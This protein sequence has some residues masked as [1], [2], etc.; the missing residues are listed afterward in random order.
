MLIP[1]LRAR[2]Y[3]AGGVVPPARSSTPHAHT[4]CARAPRIA[5][6][7]AR[8]AAAQPPPAYPRLRMQ[9]MHISDAWRPPE[10][11]ASARTHVF[12]PARARATFQVGKVRRRG[13]R[14]RAA[15]GLPWDLPALEGVCVDPP[16]CRRAR[17]RA[18]ART[19][20][21]AR[22]CAR[23]P[24]C[25]CPTSPTPR[26]PKRPHKARAHAHTARARRT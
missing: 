23:G 13:D 26:T 14:L 20:A 6:H 16:P 2:A 11:P 3:A 5:A 25:S 15:G 9:P 18:L 24:A 19:W 17:F 21:S 10:P 1:R 7:R 4:R 8:A 22:A 12:K